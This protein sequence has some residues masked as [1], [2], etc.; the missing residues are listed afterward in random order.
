[1]ISETVSN[2]GKWRIERLEE[3]GINE[4]Y[5]FTYLDNLPQILHFGL[6]P[7]NEAIKMENAPR[8]FANEEVQ[9]LRHD[10]IVELSNYQ[11]IS[12]HNLVPVYLT[13]LTPT[14]YAVR[15][16]SMEIVFVVVDA[17]ILGNDSIQFCFTDGNAGASETKIY[18]NLR[19]HKH[20][21]WEVIRAK[22]WND[23]PDGKR[24]RNAEFLIHPKIDPKWFLSLVVKNEQ[25][26]IKVESTLP[27]QTMVP[28]CIEPSFF[29]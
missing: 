14:L 23:I 22:Y 5:F 2:L 28:I 20:I 26:K 16:I 18:R 24:Q 25:V 12:V 19:H 1:M 4:F 3:A 17:K 8:S 11:K 6:L 27:V 13:P 21:P 9:K 29:F 15:D 7:K 10:R